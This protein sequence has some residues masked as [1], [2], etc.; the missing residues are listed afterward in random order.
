MTQLPPQGPGH[1][2]L[3]NLIFLGQTDRQTY[4]RRRSDPIGAGGQIS[5]YRR[6]ETT[7]RETYGRE[8]EVLMGIVH[9][10]NSHAPVSIAA[11][12]RLTLISM[13]LPVEFV[14]KGSNPFESFY[15]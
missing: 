15:S 14:F 9:R 8:R 7:E 13:Q 10:A 2:D 4:R 12:P 5:V 11:K 1:H 6:R 3:E